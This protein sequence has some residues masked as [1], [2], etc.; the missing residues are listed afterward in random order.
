MYRQNYRSFD[1][2]VFLTRGVDLAIRPAT[3]LTRVRH[4]DSVEVVTMAVV[5]MLLAEGHQKD[6]ILIVIT[7]LVAITSSL[8]NLCFLIQ[9]KQ[10]RK[11][12]LP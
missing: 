6:L 1:F 3:P 5:R 11:D 12:F 2:V 9:K 7:G 8:N 4:I 10:N